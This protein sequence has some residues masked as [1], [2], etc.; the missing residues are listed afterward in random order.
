[1][2]LNLSKQGKIEQKSSTGQKIPHK[3]LLHDGR[4]TQKNYREVNDGFLSARLRR[5]GRW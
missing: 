5:K 1:M 2:D 3:K 4:Y